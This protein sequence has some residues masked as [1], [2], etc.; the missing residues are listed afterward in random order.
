M[1]E[2]TDKE[3]LAIC[4]LSNLR[5]EFAN[6]IESETTETVEINGKKEVKK[7]L[8]NHTI[9]SLLEKEIE[10]IKLDELGKNIENPDGSKALPR[11]F[12]RKREDENKPY[13]TVYNSLDELKYT[14][15]IVYEYYEHF[16]ASNKKDNFLED[17][18][19]I[20]SGDG[21]NLTTEFI[22]YL[23]DV[24]KNEKLTKVL[25][26]KDETD[27]YRFEVRKNSD[28]E[29]DI[30]KIDSNNILV[31]PSTVDKE[32]L[33]EIYELTEQEVD[34]TLSGIKFYSPREYYESAQERIRMIK[35]GL[36]VFR[37]L[38]FIAPPIFNGIK[39]SREIAKAASSIPELTKKIS[40]DVSEEVVKAAS[41]MGNNKIKFDNKNFEKYV[42]Q[43]YPE[44]IESLNNGKISK[45]AAEMQINKVFKEGIK[46]SIKGSSKSL[47]KE[48]RSKLLSD[49]YTTN[50]IPRKVF[51]FPKANMYNFLGMDLE[52]PN[53]QA[54]K[55]METKLFEGMSKYLK[56]KGI[57][58]EVS[59]NISKYLE[60]TIV[61]GG[62]D[63]LKN[64]VSMIENIRVD[65]L[66][67]LFNGLAKELKIL[68]LLNENAAYTFFAAS[69]S[70]EYLKEKTK[71]QE[72]IPIEK[73]KIN[74]MIFELEEIKKG[75][76]EIPFQK[77]IKIDCFDFGVNIFAKTEKSEDKKAIKKIVVCFKNSS[78]DSQINER[79]RNGEL[80]NELIL[81][82]LVRGYLL[83]KIL[84]EKMELDVNKL[85]IVVT[86]FNTGAE[87]AGVF[88]MLSGYE[89]RVFKTRS[90]N[91]DAELLSFNTKDLS[92]LFY[93]NILSVLEETKEQI[94]N[95]TID[96]T[97]ALILGYVVS[98][99]T[100]IVA[101]IIFSTTVALFNLYGIYIKEKKMEEL[102]V[103][104]CKA[105]FIEC[106]KKNN[107]R[108]LFADECE[109]IREKKIF[110]PL[111]D[112]I[113]EVYKGKVALTLYLKKNNS[114]GW[115]TKEIFV[116]VED[117]LSILVDKCYSDSSGAFYLIDADSLENENY[118]SKRFKYQNFPES[119]DKEE[120]KR[121][122]KKDLGE[123]ESYKMYKEIYYDFRLQDGEYI[124]NGYEDHY[125]DIYD[126]D[127]QWINMHSESS[128]M[129]ERIQKYTINTKKID[130]ND[131]KIEMS[132][133]NI[134]SWYINI[135]HKIQQNYQNGKIKP[136][137]CF[138]TK[139]FDYGTTAYLRKE[140]VNSEYDE[141]KINNE[142]KMSNVISTDNSEF[143][144]F[145]LVEGGNIIVEK[146]D[147]EEYIVS[148]ESISNDY[149][150]SVFRSY[151]E[152]YYLKGTAKI[153]PKLDS[154]EDDKRKNKDIITDNK[155][156][157]NEYINMSPV[158]IN[159]K[160]KTK[161]DY[162][163]NIIG[164]HQIVLESKEKGKDLNME[165]IKKMEEAIFFKIKEKNITEPSFP[166]FFKI[167]EKL[168][169]AGNDSILS[170][171][172]TI[173]NETGAKA[174]PNTKILRIG[175]IE[176]GTEN[177]DE[178]SL[179]Y[180][181]NYYYAEYIKGVFFNPNGAKKKELD[182][183][184][185]GLIEFKGA[186]SRKGEKNE[187]READKKVVVSQAEIICSKS[188][189]TTSKFI[190]TTLK[191]ATADNKIIGCSKDNVP[192]VNIEKFPFC[193]SD[194][195]GIC[196]CEI[197]HET[198]WNN[199]LETSEIF[200]KI[201]TN[202]SKLVCQRGGTISI[203]KTNT[204]NMDGK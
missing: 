189:G 195:N 34:N 85:E 157:Q 176:N 99:G 118:R 95:I 25:H 145:P 153:K 58:Q 127:P 110:P 122:F 134:L 54:K 151:M 78:H 192:I 63:Y 65:N 200:G 120:F 124:V 146:L 139:G 184:R 43:K 178:K 98:G 148:N 39:K 142:E 83:P 173:S 123:T 119:R 204:K 163:C 101:S 114:I 109:Y 2:I 55:I 131:K 96:H 156:Y 81:L 77:N 177:Y 171:Y 32:K 64:I 12:M 59:E 149:I 167:L 17:W 202:K 128:K 92:N 116:K 132:S 40:G 50:K 80:Y 73:E 76:L 11:V 193:S 88:R 168:N 137:S 155:E 10:S 197:L 159:L 42:S 4:N 143:V 87:L 152:D 23:T 56:G 30:K 198:E 138:Y 136:Y 84:E 175:H 188:N 48:I 26:L 196:K 28:G 100:S 186:V 71:K 51:E 53:K 201:V 191:N 158:P 179:K 185:R 22:D 7:I 115:G 15:G 27:E 104:L 135:N 20:Y 164:G 46:I 18:E 97:I 21:Y 75:I 129:S 112:N 102:Y 79:L 49:M 108:K 154:Y 106:P 67:N 107:C 8:S 14:A 35:I 93:G 190:A 133:G 44:I 113:S 47:T 70:L 181:Y 144:F 121:I 41:K 45:E 5:M 194:K 68:T 147:N 1:N 60:E 9:Y 90:L 66:G 165:F 52:L 203:V 170:S 180:I 183:I 166:L 16:K 161:E 182:R 57:E 62:R 31:E 82:D 89:A 29:Y 72:F 130:E 24:E 36:N 141:N 162:Y 33:K 37:V 61:I 140:I 3:L 105:G 38:S 91:I 86:G 160:P 117:Y 103:A 6:I 13:S 169:K 125:A 126:D 172:Y 111:V 19:I 199:C 74:K 187:E 69:Y 94:K 174:N 150:G